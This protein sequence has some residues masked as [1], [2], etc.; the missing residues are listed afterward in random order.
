M[1]WR[2]P[3]GA[4]QWTDDGSYYAELHGGLAPTFWD[5]VS[6]GAHQAIEWAET[7]YPLAGL[8]DLTTANDEAALYL[9]QTGSQLNVNLY[10]TRPHTNAHLRVLRRYTC[11][12]LGDYDLSDVQPGV[13]I[14][15]SI[16][17]TWQ[18]QDVTVLFTADDQPLLMY[19]ITNDGQPPTNVG[20]MGPGQ[21]VTQP[22][23]PLNL[24]AMDWDCVRSF[25]VQVKDGLYGAWTNWL[26]GTVTTTHTY[27]GTHGH[28]YFFRTR[29]RDLAGNLSA[30]GDEMWGNTYR[31]GAAHT[32]TDPRTVLQTRVDVFGRGS[33]DRVHD[34][35]QQHRHRSRPL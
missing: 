9:E 23:I 10:S 35:R 17:T 6:I 14:T 18:S 30:Y 5:T 15:R 31:L 24:V 22:E 2:N 33:A 34:R 13:P 16:A 20:I 29:A 25:D 1:G 28:T 12:V 7:W 3:I 19:Q 4:E 21:Y 26:T 27:T 11:E 32:R 8:N